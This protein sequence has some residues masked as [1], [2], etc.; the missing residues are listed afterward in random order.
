LTGIRKRRALPK[1]N[2]IAGQA[3]FPGLT[4]ADVDAGPCHSTFSGNLGGLQVLATESGGLN[5][6]IGGGAGTTIGIIP[7]L[8]QWG[9]LLLGVALAYLG[10]TRLRRGGQIQ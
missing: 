5:V 9:L 2:S 8:N 4:N 3:A 6:I 10:A 1:V 7:T